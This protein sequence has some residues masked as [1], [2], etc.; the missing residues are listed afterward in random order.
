MRTVEVKLDKEAR[1]L[2]KSSAKL[3]KLYSEA[4]DKADSIA[5]PPKS[6]KPH[7]IIPIPLYATPYP[8]NNTG[9]NQQPNTH[10]PC[11]KYVAQIINTYEL[12]HPPHSAHRGE[13]AATRI[14][15][16]QHGR[17][18]DGNTL[19]EQD[20]KVRVATVAE[21]EQTSWKHVRN[22]SK[23]MF[24]GIKEAWMRRQLEG[25]VDGW[26]YQVEVDQSSGGT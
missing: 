24:M 22:E 16:K 26:G 12:E 21:L 11:W 6:S 10:R 25:E 2:L 14:N 5:P 8:E 7:T 13:K 3:G 1:R 23:F 9:H 20:G 15:A 17:V 18:V 19:I 4:N